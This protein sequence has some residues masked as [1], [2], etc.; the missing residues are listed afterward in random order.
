MG[1]YKNVL[2]WV[3]PMAIPFVVSGIRSLLR[4][5][6]NKGDNAEREVEEERVER[7]LLDN[8]IDAGLAGL[9]R[10]RGKGRNW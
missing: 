9:T 2:G 10:G 3:A 7:E 6:R 5:S 1:K 8:V 4:K